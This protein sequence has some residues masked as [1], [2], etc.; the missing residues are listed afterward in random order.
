MLSAARFAA[1]F[2]LTLLAC[3]DPPTPT[4][5]PAKSTTA[6]A[7]ATNSGEG[8][9]T[10]ASAAPTATTEPTAVE[11]ASATA[12]ASADP[13]LAKTASPSGSPTATAATS[14]APTAVA[15]APDVKGDEKKG[16]A[17]SAYMSGAGS[18]KAGQ[19]GTVTAVVNAIG[20]YHVN[21]EY[22]YKFTLNAAPAGVAYGE[23][24][25]RNVSRTEKRASISIPFTP[26]S[27][28]TATISG[29][30]SLSV[31]TSSNCV[32]EKV[33]LSVTVKVE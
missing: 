27:A 29:V 31:C 14:V 20:E 30:C 8:A 15:S 13:K 11:A 1:L 12:S 5:E 9:S 32:I 25:V 21:Q 19:A 7:T 16:A 4:A 22:P 2:S 6:A 17:F 24:V 33:P 10:T 18:Y 28:G 3:G 26:S 23:T